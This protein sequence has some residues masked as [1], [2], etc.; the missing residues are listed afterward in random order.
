MLPA[1]VSNLSQKL[2]KVVLEVGLE[3]NLD[4]LINS[5]CREA[6][7]VVVTALFWKLS[8]ALY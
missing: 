3:S 5:P 1:F 8:R 6:T 7:F 2:P 4:Y